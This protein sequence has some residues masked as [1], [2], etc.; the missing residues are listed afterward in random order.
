MDGEEVVG[1]EGEVKESMAGG[2]VKVRRG[3]R[4]EEK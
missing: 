4:R 2:C 3:E 1:G